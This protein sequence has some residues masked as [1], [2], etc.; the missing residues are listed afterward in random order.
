MKARSAGGRGTPRANA[1]LQGRPI[2]SE[3]EGMLIP[4]EMLDVIDELVLE[5]WQGR[6]VMTGPTEGATEE[7]PGSTRVYSFPG[8]QQVT[9]SPESGS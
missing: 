6:C 7:L 9:C 1:L 5:R 8:Q 2:Q 4:R 3:E